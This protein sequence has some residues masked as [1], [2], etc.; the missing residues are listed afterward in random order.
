MEPTRKKILP[1]LLLALAVT[2][3]AVAMANGPEPV[4]VVSDTV[5]PPNRDADTA[6]LIADANKNTA[7]LYQALLS[8]SG[9]M[10]VNQRAQTQAS[11]QMHD[12]QDA[13]ATQFRI[14]DWKMKATTKSAPGSSVCNVITGSVSA[15]DS[16]SAVGEWQEE[17]TDQQLDFF[18]GATSGTQS[19]R[20]ASAAMEQRIKLHCQVGA[21]TYDITNGTCP[22]GTQIQPQQTL[23]GGTTITPPV[24][25]DL[26]ANTLLNATNLTMTAADQAAANAFILQA[27]NSYV[28]GAMPAGAG[29]TDSGRR[30]AG[31]NLASAARNSVA[32]SALAAVAA[33]RK[34]MPGTGGAGNSAPPS[35]SANPAS[36]GNTVTAAGQTP[37]TTASQVSA[38]IISWAE[39]TAKM[40]IGYNQAGNNFPNGVSRAAYLKLR[41]ASWFWNPTWAASLGTQTE[42]QTLKDMALI[43]AWGVYQNWEMYRQVER[44][45]VTL[46]TMVSIMEASARPVQ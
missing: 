12:T 18:L 27:V 4:A 30:L 5:N 13:R 33:D 40:V 29:A 37:G 39:G 6:L 36:T 15:R 19:S 11:S 44:M 20:G 17:I 16:F 14:A 45:N 21:T 10:T 7:L 32:Q 8:F 28:P 23:P 31:I 2:A 43:E 42:T 25:R 46:A 3:P 9:Q 22:A 26:N 41:S 1:A 34:A 35:A 38:T 24:G